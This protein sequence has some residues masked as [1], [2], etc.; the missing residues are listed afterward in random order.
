MAS[1]RWSPQ[2][3]R[4][5]L[6]KP[7]GSLTNHLLIAMPPLAD[8]NFSQT[9]ALICEH[10][11]KGA[12]GIVLNKPLPM[13]LC[14]R[15]LA[16][17]A[18]ALRPSASP[19]SRCCAAARCTPIAASCCTVPAASGIH[20]HK[21]SDTIQVTTSRDVLA[22][23]ATRRGARGCLRRARLRRLG[24][25]AARARDAGQRLAVGA[26][27]CERGVRTALR[28]ALAGAP[29]GCLGMDVERLSLDRRPCLSAPAAGHDR[30]QIVLAFDFGLRRIGIAS[31]R[32]ADAQRRAAPGG[33]VRH[34]AAR[35]GRAIAREVR[36]LA[37]GTLLVV[38]AP[39]NADGSDAAITQRRRAPLRRRAR[40]PLRHCPCDLVDERCSSLRGDRGAAA[41]SAPAAS[42]GG[43]C[44]RADIDSAA[45][46]VILERWFAG[47]R[48]QRD[49]EARTR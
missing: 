8:P 18:R 21:V 27:G 38:G 44:R 5:P 28:G 16:D 41:R 33:A 2:A 19:R 7:A 37:P 34:A 42:A 12:L 15:A 3:P 13:K 31:R 24:V 47:E 40:T 48:T 1:L 23:M 32:H 14:G 22:A 49:D 17:E 35:T 46:A 9:V 10:S 6:P 4:R 30:T 11:D 45:A 25:R 36:A 39:Y 29:G 20:T 43:A 26:G